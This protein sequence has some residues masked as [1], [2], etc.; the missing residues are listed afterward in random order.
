MMPSPKRPPLALRFL[1]VG[2]VLLSGLFA[3]GNAEAGGIQLLRGRSPV[4]EL[5]SSETLYR[6]GLVLEIQYLNDTVASQIESSKTIPSNDAAIHFCKAV[7][8]QVRS[9]CLCNSVR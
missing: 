4:R 6:V 8:A 1:A 2:F 3:G 7:N 9:C 5:Q